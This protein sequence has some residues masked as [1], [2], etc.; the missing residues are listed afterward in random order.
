MQVLK[1]YYK[2]ELIASAIFFIVFVWLIGWWKALLTAAILFLLSLVL[3]D[4]LIKEW[5]RPRRR[6]RVDEQ[7]LR[8]EA[9][10]IEAKRRQGQI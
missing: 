3:V 10:R 1:K 6:K 7:F 4:Y 8:Q 2:R 9:E 5:W